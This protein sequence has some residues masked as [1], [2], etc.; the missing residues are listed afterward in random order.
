MG[1][2][3]MM[4]GVVVGGGRSH[5]NVECVSDAPWGLKTIILAGILH[6]RKTGGRLA[7]WYKTDPRKVSGV[8]SLVT[9]HNVPCS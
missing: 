6:L 7:G 5:E 9:C 2:K 4:K 3:K 1:K 8:T